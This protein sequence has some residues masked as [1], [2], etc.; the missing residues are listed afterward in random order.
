MRAI[1]AALAAAAVASACVPPRVTPAVTR[2]YA[3]RQFGR[4]TAHSVTL[5]AFTIPVP[6]AAASA[7]G[8]TTLAPEAQAEVVKA[9]AGH[10]S[11][12]AS[13]TEAIGL[14]IG[15]AGGAAPFVDLTRVSRRLVFSVENRSLG[16][17]DRVSL[18]RISIHP[19]GEAAFRGW[20]RIE[21][22]YEQVDLGKLNLTRGVTNTGEIGATVPF[23][24]LAPKVSTSAT[25]SL[26]EDVALTQRYAALTGAMTER[27]AVLLQQGVTGIDL[28][29]TVTADVDISL[30]RGADVTVRHV[31]IPRKDGAPDCSAR[32][33]FQRQVVRYPRTADSVWIA[34]GLEYL[35]RRVQR[36]D[37]TI[38]ESDDSV[39]LE[40]GQDSVTK[41]LAIPGE[42]LK[43][44]VYQLKLGNEFVEIRDEHEFASSLLQVPSF[45]EAFGLL[46][47]LR[48]CGTPKH[49]T[50]FSIARRPLARSDLRALDVILV[51]M[52]WHL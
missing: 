39:V 12:P 49:G 13:L 34:A 15:G 23:L 43:Y 21:N 30:P 26:V 36:G 28:T 27:E 11:T 44:S 19:Q 47:W 25:S 10:T 3:H 40:L 17:A 35:L 48:A 9:V 24:S 16:P 31:A 38:T 7:N 45:D 8:I 52:N 33:V 51:P 37:E 50:L 2:R 41:V 29:G 32:P 22:R 4:D 18:A 5:T 14:P 42:D 20:N 1:L 46:G 6:A